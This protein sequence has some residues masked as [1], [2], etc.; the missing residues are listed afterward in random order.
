ML[1]ILNRIYST[2]YQ[3]ANNEEP[4]A[5]TSAKSAKAVTQKVKIVKTG[6][7]TVIDSPGTN[8]P[9]KKRLHVTQ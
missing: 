4:L 7:M 1:T 9:D 5:F 3:E 6:N 8:D 2:D